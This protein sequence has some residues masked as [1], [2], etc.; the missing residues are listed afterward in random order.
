MGSSASQRTISASGSGTLNQSANLSTSFGGTG[1]GHRTVTNNISGQESDQTLKKASEQMSQSFSIGHSRSYHEIFQIQK[2]NK[3]ML[4]Q[5][6]KKR[7]GVQP[8]F[9]ERILEEIDDE[10][11]NGMESNSSSD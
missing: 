2:I 3:R 4:K 5:V 11:R 8:S 7:T 6:K 10:D 1:R 9:P